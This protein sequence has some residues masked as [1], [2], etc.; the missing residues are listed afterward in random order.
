MAP[1]SDPRF[2]RLSCLDVLF[3]LFQYVMTRIKAAKVRTLFLVNSPLSRPV[4]Q[5]RYFPG[6]QT[7]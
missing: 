5:S 4:N 2:L 1:Q 3:V 7:I 6:T